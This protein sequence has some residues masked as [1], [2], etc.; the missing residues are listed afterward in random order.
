VT[1]QHGGTITVDSEQ[2]VFTEFTV[3]LPR[4]VQA[5]QAQDRH[6]LTLADRI[7]GHKRSYGVHSRRKKSSIDIGKVFGPPGYFGPR[8][9]GNFRVHRAEQLADYLMS[10]GRVSGAH[11]RDRGGEQSGAVEDVGIFGEEAEDQPRHKV[12]HVVAATGG[13]PFRVVLQKLDI[14]PVQTAGGPDVERALA[15]WLDCGDPG[16]GQEETEVV[17]EFLIGAGDRLAGFQVLGL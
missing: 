10:I 3:R 4:R 17:R 12:V 5:V 6:G 15:D 16:E 14:K 9:I 11:L 8:P 13:S 2:G 1:R 7:G